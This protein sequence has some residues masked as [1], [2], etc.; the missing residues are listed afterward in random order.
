MSQ[1]AISAEIVEPYAEALMS[2]AQ[3]EDIV[4]R[5]SDDVNLLMGLLRES[6]D[7]KDFLTSPLAPAEAKKAVL[8]QLTQD[9]AHPYTLNFLMLLVDRRRIPLLEGICK[10][11][12]TLVRKRNNAVLAEI[13]STV[14]LSEQQ[15]QTV[16]EKVKAMTGAQQVEL[17]TRI[18]PD[19]IGGVVI[20][21][22]SQVLDAS[23][24]GQL[25]RLTNSL[26]SSAT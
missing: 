17:E 11:Y 8:Q 2:A 13:T 15:R 23:I 7:L 21:V 16:I 12:Q 18:D 6:Q 20:K 1:K 5:V 19:L 26:M 24:R 4:D 3:A 10:H 14:E 9:Q 25:R 22:G